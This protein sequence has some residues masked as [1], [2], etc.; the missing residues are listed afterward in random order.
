MKWLARILQVLLFLFIA[1]A[2]VLKVAS[3]P[4]T[5][6]EI[7]AEPYGYSVW[8]IY[9]IGVFELLAAVGLIVGFWRPRFA[10]AALAIIFIILLGALG[11]TLYAGLCVEAISPLIGLMLT[12][13]VY[14]TNRAMLKLR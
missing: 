8:F 13:A 12:V 14:L 1:F 4:E 5:I 6:R 10:F 11:S 7:F 2:G 9:V 3:D